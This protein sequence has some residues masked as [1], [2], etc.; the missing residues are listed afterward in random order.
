MNLPDKTIPFSQIE[1]HPEIINCREKADEIPELAMSIEQQGLH[2]PPTVLQIEDNGITHYYLVAGWRRYAAVQFIRTKNPT[3]YDKI[4]VRP[5]RMTLAD[6]QIV[7]LTENLQR[8]DLSPM[9]VANAVERLVLMGFKQKDISEK[10]GKS[11]SWVSNALAFKRTAVPALRNAVTDGVI[12]FSMAQQLAT[13]SEDK[14]RDTVAR[15]MPPLTPADIAPE[16]SDCDIVLERQAQDESM[17]ATL[18]E[19]ISDTTLA[20]VPEAKIEV[21][22][23]TADRRKAADKK[24]E[25]KP[26]TQ[27][28]KTEIRREI[29]EQSE[30]KIRPSVKEVRSEIERLE[31]V[32]DPDPYTQ[33]LIVA[34]KWS[35]GEVKALE[36]HS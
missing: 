24:I 28:V 14:Q 25:A 31:G 23:R 10:L 19:N 2:T 6:A 13:L 3:A 7:N 5:V 1:F 32:D 17:L 9:E 27:K 18:P 35:L 16:K 29:R 36:L 8:K 30:K 34:L 21:E 33:G 15:L 26:A 20:S 22:D 4:P 11:Q 12:S